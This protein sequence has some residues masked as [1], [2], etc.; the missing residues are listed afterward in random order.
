MAKSA[1]Q[2]EIMSGKAEKIGA[3]L[4]TQRERK[5]LSF[6]Q[7]Y[8][9]TRI[10][11]EILKGIE[12]GSA[13]VAPVFLKGFIKTYAKALGIEEED[14]QKEGFG[15]PLEDEQDEKRNQE[16]KS[17]EEKTLEEKA[18]EK[19]SLEEK[20]LKEESLEEK[21]LEEKS[22][23][24]KTPGKKFREKPQKKTADKKESGA[25]LRESQNQEKSQKR[26]QKLKEKNIKK[27][28]KRQKSAAQKLALVIGAL[29]L[30]VLF[31]KFGLKTEGLENLFFLK[32]KNWRGAGDSRLSKAASSPESSQA[33]GEKAE[34][35]KKAE[36]S[37]KALT[38]AQEKAVQENLE[39]DQ[40]ADALNAGE[41]RSA[42]EQNL[43]TKN[44]EAKNP[45]KPSSL[46]Q[47]GAE[48]EGAAASSQKIESSQAAAPQTQSLAREK[49]QNKAQP[50]PLGFL[51]QTRQGRFK[52]EILVRARAVPL[53]IYFKADSSSIMVKNLQ[54]FQWYSIKAFEKIYLR[55]DDDPSFVELFHNGQEVKRK[56]EGFFERAFGESAPSPSFSENQSQ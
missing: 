16:K 41:L 27:I 23:K 50:A 36:A 47:L 18:L 29:L 15:A 32:A 19:K 56:N 24:K 39:T 44:I 37:S 25:P 12:E 21:S 46:N 35:E 28:A 10:Q 43:E 11:P 20:P 48:E 54:P 49:K 3:F 45:A 5:G 9:L 1:E 14:L 13:K 40:T 17:L 2:R 26:D 6:D 53:E 51:A 7:I 38:E 4:K 52:E 55:L 34:R 30:G 22:A 8:D 42:E 31:V 33:E